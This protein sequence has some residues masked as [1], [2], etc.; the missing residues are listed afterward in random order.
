MKF[1][2]GVMSIWLQRHSIY[3]DSFSKRNSSHW[4]GND[5]AFISKKQTKN[6]YA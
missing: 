1:S 5:I 6:I 3:K 4:S 2:L